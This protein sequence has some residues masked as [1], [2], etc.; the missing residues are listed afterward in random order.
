MEDQFN[1]VALRVRV[2]ASTFSEAHFLLRVLWPDEAGCSN[3]CRMI[4]RQ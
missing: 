2:D 3:K 4:R 1:V